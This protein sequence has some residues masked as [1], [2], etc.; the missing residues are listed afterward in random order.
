[1]RSFR[2][3]PSLMRWHRQVIEQTAQVLGRMPE[4][5]AV[6]WLARL[7]PKQYH[8]LPQEEAAAARQR[9]RGHFGAVNSGNPRSADNDQID[10]DLAREY[11]S[12]H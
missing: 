7:T 2:V 10:A 3:K 4:A 6:E 8:Q 9:F 12:T 11:D 5:L 1:M